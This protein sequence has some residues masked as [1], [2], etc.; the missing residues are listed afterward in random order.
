MRTSLLLSAA[1]LAACA[2]AP[3]PRSVS[4]SAEGWAPV[5][6][7]GLEH[8][9][10]RALADA[11]RRAAE[12]GSGVTVEGRSEVKDAVT[13]TSDVLTKAVGVVRSW[14]VVKEEVVDGIMRLFIAAVVVDGPVRTSNIALK[15]DDERAES[16]VA[17]ALQE[18]G[19]TVDRRSRTK[20]TGTA[21]A[22]ASRASYIPGTE[23]YRASAELVVS[24][25]GG[26]PRRVF[27]EA[28]ALDADPDQAS[29]K[30]VEAAGYRA[31]LALAALLAARP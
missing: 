15:V 11:L 7:D 27:E 2:H 28:S 24:T 22:R 9:R 25:E 18:K 8:A 12:K 13:L 30:A 16:G 21:R 31:G 23:T 17:K 29:A 14:D 6:A 26:A 3:Q 20:V 4:V 10:D 19:F 5:G 1:L